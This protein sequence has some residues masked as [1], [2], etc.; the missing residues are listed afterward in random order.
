MISSIYQIDFITTDGSATTYSLL[1]WGDDIEKE[2]EFPVENNVQKFSAIWAAFGK[3]RGMG[4][5]RRT[6]TFGRYVEHNNHPEA[7]GYCLT[8]PA[9]L[10]LAIPGKI[11]VTIPIVAGSSYLVYD[12]LDAVIIAAIAVKSPVGDFTTYT[13]YRLEG[14]K[15]VYVSG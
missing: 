15:T 12:V 2:I 10:P 14:G 3:G 6:I 11:R 7:A 9:S 4:G 8:H 1:S 13:T 5:A